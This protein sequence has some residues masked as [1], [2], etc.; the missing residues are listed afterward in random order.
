MFQRRKLVEQNVLSSHGEATRYFVAFLDN[1]DVKERIRYVDPAHP[2][3]VN[4]V[5]L[6]LACLYS[7]PGSPVQR[8]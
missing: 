7:R 1:H 8:R 4:Q 3:F 5:T 6:R 2:E